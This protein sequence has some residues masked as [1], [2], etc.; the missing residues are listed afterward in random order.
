MNSVPFEPYDFFGYL[1]SGLVVVLG[2]DLTFGFPHVLGRDLKLVDGAV[3]LLGTYVAG[4]IAATPAKALLEYG[5]VGK[6]LGR[7]SVNLFRE[8]VPWVRRLSFPDFY[9]PFP[10][11]IREKILSRAESEGVRGTG[12]TLFLHVR[13]S[14]DILQN[15][16]L[17]QKMNSFLNQYGFARNLAF[18][19]LAVGIAWI[20][21]AKLHPDPQLIRYAITALVTAALLL[22]RYLKFFRQYSYEMF[23][24]YG[25]SGT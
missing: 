19:S 10:K 12:E 25:G 22:Y 4:Q 15:E 17:M 18:T 21:K 8:K 1:A 9:K 2:M 16:K 14:P 11:H 23:N 3:L 7:P 6:I 20:T 24:T 5:L 13:Y